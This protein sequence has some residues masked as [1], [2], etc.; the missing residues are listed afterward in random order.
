MAVLW[1]CVF[2]VLC[3][4]LRSYG[5]IVLGL[6][7]IP[8]I[9][10]TTLCTKMLTMVNSSS[11]QVSNTSNHVRQESKFSF[12]FHFQNIFPATDWQDFFINSQSW[13]SAAQEAFLTWALFGASIISI[14]SKTTHLHEKKTALRRDA[15]IVVLITITGLILAAVLANACVQVLNDY[16]YYYFP[17]SYGK[18]LKKKVYLPS[19]RTT[20]L[21]QKPSALTF[22]YFHRTLLYHLN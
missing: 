1:L 13:L 17:G 9:G 12:N 20:C 21:L 8:F 18:K 4:G 14:F 19:K 16:G 3:K 7:V 6:M 5:K 2:V 10:L 11:L 15:V 22:F